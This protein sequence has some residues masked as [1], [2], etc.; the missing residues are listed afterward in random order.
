[1]LAVPVEG[2]PWERLTP[3]PLLAPSLFGFRR[4]HRVP[5]VR[6]NV[7]ELLFPRE[8]PNHP[9][10]MTVPPLMVNVP[11]EGLPVVPA[12]DPISTPPRKIFV[13]LFATNLPV[14]LAALPMAVTS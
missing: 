3:P 9:L 10:S 13:P 6:L 4:I 14:P 2:T 8:T 7:P 5:P 12:P 1:M 11:V